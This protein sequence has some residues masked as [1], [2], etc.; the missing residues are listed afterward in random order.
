MSLSRNASA[1]GNCLRMPAAITLLLVT[2]SCC[3]CWKKPSITVGPDTATPSR[4]G[5]SLFT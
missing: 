1:V 2:S 5:V 4:R 3:D